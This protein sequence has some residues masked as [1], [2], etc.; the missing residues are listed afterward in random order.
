MWLKCEGYIRNAVYANDVPGRKRRGRESSA[1]QPGFIF[2]G[3][4]Q[5][6]DACSR[7]IDVIMLYA[8]RVTSSY[9]IDQTVCEIDE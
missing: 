7:M 3:N 6:A 8:V 1:R 2:C 4:W 5:K 9:R